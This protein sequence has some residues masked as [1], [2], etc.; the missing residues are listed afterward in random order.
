MRAL[1][2]MIAVLVLTRDTFV[3]LRSGPAKSYQIS[4]HLADA[5]RS[6]QR[7]LLDIGDGP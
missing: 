6:S 1:K 5:R 4:R 7:Q 2:N 3:R